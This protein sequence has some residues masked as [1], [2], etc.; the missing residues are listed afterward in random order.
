MITSDYSAVLLAAKNLP[1][2]SDL[3]QVLPL[4]ILHLDTK[5][6]KI[7]NHSKL[8]RRISNADLRIIMVLTAIHAREVFAQDLGRVVVFLAKK[9]EKRMKISLFAWRE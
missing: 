8:R 3:Q 7:P 1:L 6:P 2:I 5:F 9:F 4:F